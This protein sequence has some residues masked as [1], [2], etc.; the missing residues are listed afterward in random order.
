MRV[1]VCDAFS[2]FVVCQLQNNN[3]NKSVKKSKPCLETFL[4]V[5]WLSLVD[6]I[7]EQ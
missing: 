4:A 6:K 3:N 5:R 2:P 1:L 7:E